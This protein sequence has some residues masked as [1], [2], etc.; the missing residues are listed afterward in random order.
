MGPKY[1]LVIQLPFVD[2]DEKRFDSILALEARIN[3]VLRAVGEGTVDG[4]DFGSGEMNI[5]IDT[6]TP[7]SVFDALRPTLESDPALQDF[8]VG[9]REN[10]QDEYDVIWPRS[11]KRFTVI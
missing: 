3:D 10:G 8:R 9:F 5:F 2:G 11:L 6:S 1:Q 7:R 4:N